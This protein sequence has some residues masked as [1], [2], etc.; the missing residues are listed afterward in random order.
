M[1]LHEIK[2]FLKL[3][4]AEKMDAVELN[5]LL[6]LLLEHVTG[7]NQVQQVLH[8]NESLTESQLD[9]LKNAAKELA[10]DKPIQYILGK[11]WFMGKEYFVNENVLIPRP[12]TEEL[13]DWISEYA[14]II[15]KPLQLLDIGTGSGCIA[16]SL[17][18]ELPNCNIS[19]LDVSSPALEVAKKNATYLN[20]AIE[21]VEQDILMSASLPASYDIIVSN[22]PYIPFNEKANM[23]AQVKNFEPAIALFVTNEDPLI[24]YRIIARLGK[25]FLNPNGQL[26][27]EMH[28]DQ[29]KAIVALFDEMG[30]HAELR[31]DMFGKDRMIRASLKPR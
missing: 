30:Y 23:Q 21:W 9:Q 3:Q 5:S 26:F 31:Q 1:S 14:H 16:I 29:G 25:Q 24:F 13:V 22:P 6:S 27:F 19:G 8:K 7:W 20:A 2:Q 4:L 11:A 17:K 18:L 10:A 12:E 15:N 28:Y